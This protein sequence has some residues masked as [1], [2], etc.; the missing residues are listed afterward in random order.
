VRASKGRRALVSR[1]GTLLSRPVTP[2]CGPI[3]RS[4]S[5]Q[6]ANATCHSDL[7]PLGY[8]ISTHRPADLRPATGTIVV[9]AIETPRFSEIVS[10]CE[11]RLQ[12]TARAIHVMDR[13]GDNYDLLSE[14]EAARS[15]APRW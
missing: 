10:T 6:S 8:V 13:E 15:L 9:P 1:K 3:W 4:P 2:E 12:G 5:P 14:L 7:S 11:Q